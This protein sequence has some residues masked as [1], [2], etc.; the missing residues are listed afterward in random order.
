MTEKDS[1]EQKAEKTAA[2]MKELRSKYTDEQIHKA[3]QTM[4]QQNIDEKLNKNKQK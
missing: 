4:L 3:I 2:V 1:F